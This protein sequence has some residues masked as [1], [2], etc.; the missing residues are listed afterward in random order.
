MV[1]VVVVPMMRRVG[2]T[3][4]GEKKHRGRNSKNL[5]HDSDPCSV[6]RK[7][8]PAHHNVAGDSG[9]VPS[10]VWAV[11]SEGVPFAAFTQHSSIDK[12]PEAVSYKL[13]TKHGDARVHD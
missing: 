6:E 12:D 2:Q 13:I 1:V 7:A 4:I 11:T 5:A 9:R 8:L 10:S 3:D